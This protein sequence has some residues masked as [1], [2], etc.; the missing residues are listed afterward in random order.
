M[1]KA[2]LRRNWFRSARACT[3]LKIISRLWQRLRQLEV[4]EKGE[5]WLFLAVV[6][7]Q[8]Y[9]SLII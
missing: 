3:D 5:P 4:L 7:S 2:V 8:F 1:E 9:P 6:L